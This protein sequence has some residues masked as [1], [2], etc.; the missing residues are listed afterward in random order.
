VEGVAGNLHGLQFLFSTFLI[1]ALPRKEG[2][3]KKGE[4]KLK[5]GG[6]KRKGAYIPRCILLLHPVH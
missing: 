4:K 1:H 3:K 2:E 5:E 6:E